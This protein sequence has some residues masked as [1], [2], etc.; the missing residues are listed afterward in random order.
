MMRRLKNGITVFVNC[1]IKDS[2]G[3]TLG[4]VGVGLRVD[5]LQTLL[6]EYEDK[7]GVNSFLINRLGVTEISTEKTGFEKTDHFKTSGYAHLKNEILADK[8]ITESRPLWLTEGS[9]KNYVVA[10]YI[11]D[12]SWHLIIEHDTRQLDDQL[13]CQLMKNALVAT[14]II[15]IILVVIT[16]VI[17]SYNRR[18]VEMTAAHEA[19]RQASFREATEQLY[20]N[21]IEINLSE[22]K[23]A[24]KG[25]EDYFEGLGMPRNVPFDQALATIAKTKIKEE[26]RE[27]YLAAFLP[28]NILKAYREGQ[29]ARTFEFMMSQ[30]GK[31][32]Y[33]SRIIAHVYEC[34][35]DG[36]VCL[37]SYHKN[38]DEEKR[39]NLELAQQ[40]QMDA[41]TGLYNK[42]TSERL[43]GEELQN[44]PGSP[45][46]FIILDIDNFKQINDRYGHTVGDH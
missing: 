5:H 34:A 2:N 14:G 17:R 15:G 31:H 22:N 25:A 19:E 23:A 37:F 8:D 24:S 12:L 13:R 30:D 7:F 3:T 9:N 11:P 10:K 40:A 41:M 43:I 44:N 32:C 29:T 20:G 42:A 36:S 27:G 45:H 4:V 18:I 35:E 1:R 26:Y 16:C 39:L 46:A 21:I 6:K 28:E 38:I 33:W